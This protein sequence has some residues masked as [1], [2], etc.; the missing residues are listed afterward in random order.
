MAAAIRW[1][2]LGL[3]IAA[4]VVLSY[5]TI[6]SFELGFETVPISFI[7]AAILGCLVLAIGL[8]LQSRR[9][10]STNGIEL[11]LDRI[12]SPTTPPESSGMRRESGHGHTPAEPCATDG[13]GIADETT[14]DA[15]PTPADTSRD[16]ADPLSDVQPNIGLLSP[17]ERPSHP[18]PSPPM[19]ASMP[20][21]SREIPPL[22]TRDV[23]DA[24]VTDDTGLDAIRLATALNQY[25]QFGLRSDSYVVPDSHDSHGKERV[26]G[27][28]DLWREL[29]DTYG[30]ESIDL[31]DIAAGRCRITLRSGNM[32]FYVP[33]YQRWVWLVFEQTRVAASTVTILHAVD[34]DVNNPDWV[35]STSPRRPITPDPVEAPTGVA[36]HEEPPTGLMRLARSRLGR[37]NPN[38]QAESRAIRIVDMTQVLS[39]QNTPAA[40]E[41]ALFVTE[42]LLLGAAYGDRVVPFEELVWVVEAATGHSLLLQSMGRFLGDLVERS[43]PRHMSVLSALAVLASTSSEPSVGTRRTTEVGHA[44]PQDDHASVTDG[45][46]VDLTDSGIHTQHQTATNRSS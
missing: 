32:V 43:Y 29:V 16:L 15:Q 45:T 33:E 30:A 37:R 25:E 42:G 20:R 23:F 39:S 14:R 7:A 21:S 9:S 38:L 41:E 22:P 10:R 27:E 11:R 18:V 1:I 46:V 19:T 36:T 26:L 2:F 35:N 34:L 40:Y 3:V 12:A 28:Q 13:S 5:V 6:E 31:R 17:D 44:P 8:Y 24:T 4:I